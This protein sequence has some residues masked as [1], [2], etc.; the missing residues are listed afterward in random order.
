MIK[1]VFAATTDNGANIVN[2]IVDHLK[3]I[4]MPCIGHTFQLSIKKAFDLPTVQ[5]VLGRCQKCIAHFNKST[6]ET[7]KL[8]EKQKLLKLPQH[9]LIQDCITRWGSTLHMLERIQEQQAAIAAVLMEGHN[10][11]LIPDGEEWITID[12]LISVLKPFQ[13][14]TEAMSGERYSTISTVK[15]LLFKLLKV[16]LEVTDSDSQTIKR[17]KEVVSSDLQHRYSE[18]CI[19]QLLNVA[20]YLDPRYKNLP[21]L[22]EC[23]KRKAL[24]DVETMVMTH[25]EDKSVEETPLEETES[26][27]PQKKKKS[28]PLSKL[29]GDIFSSEKLPKNHTDRARNEYDMKQKKCLI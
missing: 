5:R 8:R 25:S 18:K 19:K 15:P 13:N 21:F 20:T 4:H 1:K 29:L 7:Y 26:L 23:E 22:A 24:E 17:I 9:E 12:G 2:S 3:L 6:K 28:G 27:L 10:T 14:A 16:T 11:H